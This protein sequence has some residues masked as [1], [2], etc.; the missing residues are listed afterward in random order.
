MVIP[1]IMGTDMEKGIE[2]T[3]WGIPVQE[4]KVTIS[5]WEMLVEITGKDLEWVLALE[6]DLDQE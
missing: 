4:I 5:Q 1:K 3:E 6:L 2:E